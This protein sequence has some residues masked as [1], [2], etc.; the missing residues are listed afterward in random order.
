M[1]NLFLTAR[2][3]HFDDYCVRISDKTY[4]AQDFGKNEIKNA[5]QIILE[6]Y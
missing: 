6:A 2:S 1:R 4:E 3:G 5:A